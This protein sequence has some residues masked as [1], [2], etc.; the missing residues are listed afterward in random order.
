MK[1]LF[2]TIAFGLFSTFAYAQSS[3]D[4]PPPTELPRPSAM[5][6]PAVN[7]RT[8]EAEKGPEVPKIADIPPGTGAV[9]QNAPAGRKED[10]RPEADKPTTG[11]P[12]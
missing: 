12:E 11:N 1:I 8:N 9:D 7:D 5:A 4:I 6:A 2:A 10:L 3:H